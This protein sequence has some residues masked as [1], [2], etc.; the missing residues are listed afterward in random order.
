MIHIA[1]AP[2]RRIIADLPSRA[3]VLTPAED[4]YGFHI[5]HPNSTYRIP[6]GDGPIFSVPDQQPPIPGWQPP[7]A[8]PKR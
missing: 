5:R 1:S 4:P 3:K 2:V 7:P 6:M 8:K